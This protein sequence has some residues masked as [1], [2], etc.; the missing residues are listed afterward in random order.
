M[1]CF[2]SMAS[3]HPFGETFW[4]Y[5]VK[6]FAMN[7]SSTLGLIPVGYGRVLFCD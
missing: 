3:T 2:G 4:L 1:S 6:R 7:K 5:S